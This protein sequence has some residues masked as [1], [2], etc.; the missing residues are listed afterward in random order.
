MNIL[1]K[2]ARD[3]LIRIYINVRFDSDLSHFQGHALGKSNIREW[4]PAHVHI[5]IDFELKCGESL[6]KTMCKHNGYF[7]LCSQSV[8]PSVVIL[9]T[10]KRS[11]KSW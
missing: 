11:D 9:L 7:P 2:T 10:T 8:F 5:F 6:F 4:F 1:A 3:M